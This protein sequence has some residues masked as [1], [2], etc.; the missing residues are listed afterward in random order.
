VTAHHN[1]FVLALSL[2]TSVSCG[3]RLATA[4]ASETRPLDQSD[5]VT[6]R[7][8][9]TAPRVEPAAVARCGGSAWGDLDRCLSG[10]AELIEGGRASPR[11]A[12]RKQAP[13]PEPPPVHAAR[14]AAPAADVI[15]RLYFGPE[16]VSIDAFADALD[17]F[18]QLAV[19]NRDVRLVVVAPVESRKSRPDRLS[20]RRVEAVRSYL[21]QRGVP[22]A[23]IVVRPRG[24]EPRSHDAAGDGCVE[25]AT[26]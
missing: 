12:R 22:S 18:A 6:V 15:D 7:A 14:V 25:L 3:S 19:E 8:E 24:A 1:A 17:A 11:R 4:P 10:K 23:R 13:A 9:A 26:E 20:A 5:S 21:V 2:A 16:A